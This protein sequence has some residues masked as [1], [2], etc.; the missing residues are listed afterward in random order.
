MK[1]LISLALL[2]VMLF[3]VSLAFAKTVEPEDTDYERLAGRVINAT[4]GEYNPD[5]KTFTVYLYENDRFEREDV[6]KIAAGDTLLAG[7]Y[8]YKVKEISPAED[9]EFKLATEDGEE[10]IFSPKGDDDMILMNVINDRRYTH[11]FAVLHLPA[12]EGLVYEDTTDPEKM[13]PVVTRGL[14]EILKIKE[15]REKTSIGFDHYATVIEL[16]DALEIVRIHQDYDVA[17]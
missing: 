8:L 1:K 15:E 14:D 16:N 17:Q 13:E 2:A 6:A 3:S 5:T 4:V 7:G 11:V 12:A 10:M 9:G